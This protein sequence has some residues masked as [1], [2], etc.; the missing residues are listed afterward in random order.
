M[1][2]VKVRLT[3]ESTVSEN[4]MRRTLLSAAALAMT[5]GMLIGCQSDPYAT[6]Y[7]AVKQNLSPEMRGTAERPVDSDMHAWITSDVNM[8]SAWDDAGRAWLFDRPVGS[9]MPVYSTSG[10]PH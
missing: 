5:A 2:E 3:P 8:R 1:I 9:P 6:D 10:M 7:T 4:E